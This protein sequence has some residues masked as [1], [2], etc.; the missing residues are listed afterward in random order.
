MRTNNDENKKK[1]TTAMD[2]LRADLYK[3]V[4]RFAEQLRRIVEGAFDFL[5]STKGHVPTVDGSD[6]VATL[7]I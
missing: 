5:H 2:A 7:E 4:E 6:T 1:T 3:N